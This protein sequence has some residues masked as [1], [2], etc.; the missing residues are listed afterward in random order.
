[1]FF[2]AGSLTA[3]P[4]K[5]TCTVPADTPILFPVANALCSKAFRDPRPYTKCARDTLNQALVDSTTFARL[6][7]E[8]LRIQ[9]I[10]SGPF[11]WTIESEDNPF[12]VPKGTFPAASVG[13]WVYLAQG[14]P[15]GKHTLRFGGEFPNINFRQDITY[16]LRVV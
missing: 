13:L 1:V 14:L 6:D 16:K 4:M 7:G 5:R 8:K 10:A 15:E 2:L 3:E 12:G 11:S 9:R